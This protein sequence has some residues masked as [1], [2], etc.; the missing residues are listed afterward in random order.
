MS[1]NKIDTLTAYFPD[2]A[3]GTKAWQTTVDMRYDLNKFISELLPESQLQR[4]SPTQAH[5]AED[6]HITNNQVSIKRL[7]TMMPDIHNNGMHIRTNVLSYRDVEKALPQII[8]KFKDLATDLGATKIMHN[9]VTLL[10]KVAKL[11]IAAQVATT[12][13]SLVSSYQEGTERIQ[14]FVD[15]KEVSPETARDYAVAVAQAAAINTSTMAAD[16]S[17]AAIPLAQWVHEHPEV[18]HNVLEAL[19]LKQIREMQNLM[20]PSAP[21]MS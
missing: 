7:T 11:S 19:G 12:S 17:L 1:P 2:L 8:Q 14:P 10:S 9:S 5:L 16:Q 6:V 20:T 21:E 13:I 3:Y 4:K 15:S 18:P